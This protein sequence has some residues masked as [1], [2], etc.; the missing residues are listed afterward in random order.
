MEEQDRLCAAKL[1]QLRHDIQDGLNSGPAAAWDAGEIKQEGAQKKCRPG[2][3][4]SRVINAAHSHTAAR[5]DRSCGNL[6]FI[7]EDSQARADSFLDRA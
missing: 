6:G 2:E 7:T 1:D 3:W 5:A 4:P